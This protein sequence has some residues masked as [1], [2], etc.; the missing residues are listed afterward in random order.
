MAQV[1]THDDLHQAFSDLLQVLS[2]SW[3]DDDLAY[4]REELS[5]GEYGDALENTIALGI[6]RDFHFDARQVATITK[7][8]TAMGM[9]DSPFLTTLRKAG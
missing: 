6:Q 7:L 4:I 8:A 3:P 1:T 5:H 2:T 9:L